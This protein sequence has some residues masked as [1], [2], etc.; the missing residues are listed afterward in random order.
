MSLYRNILKQALSITW[1]HK[2]LWFFGLFATLI[3]GGGEYQVLVRGIGGDT[4]QNLFPNFSRLAETGIF[5]RTGLANMGGLLKTDPV[6]AIILILVSL[7]I[8][9]LFIFLI[10]LMIVSQTAL[11]NN[12]AEIIG[13]KKELPSGVRRGVA[14]GVKY[15][16][17]VLGLNIIIKIIICLAFFLISL[18]VVFWAARMSPAITASLYIIL[19]ILLIPLAIV[20]SFIVKYAICYVV[21]KGSR[22]ADAIK[23][24][25]QLFTKNWLISIEM[26]F[27]LFFI[28]FLVGLAII[29]AVLILIVPFLFLALILYKA[30]SFIGFWLIIIVGLVVLLAIVVGG[31]AALTTFQITSWTGLFT[32]LVSRGGVSKIER[33]VE[34]WRK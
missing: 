26:A 7:V 8:L 32:E 3:G 5:S 9:A 20:L 21:I 13:N 6:T 31:G 29:L 4:T 34:G 17:P 23:E 15:F 14:A 28:S 11:V 33:I 30:I 18:P 22:F 10:W 19:F 27:I 12:S 1:R 16:W 2:Y 25:W 24:G